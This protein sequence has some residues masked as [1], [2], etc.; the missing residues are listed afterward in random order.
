MTPSASEPNVTLE[1][2]RRL[3][4]ELCDVSYVE[5]E[6][7]LDGAAPELAA[8]VRELLLADAEPEQG[9]DAPIFERRSADVPSARYAGI[10]QEGRV[11]GY[12]YQLSSDLSAMLAPTRNAPDWQITVMCDATEDRCDQTRVGAVPDAA[13]P[14]VVAMPIRIVSGSVNALS[15]ASCHSEKSPSKPRATARATN[16]DAAPPTP[17][18]AATSS[19][20]EVI[21]TRVESW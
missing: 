7:R 14:V 18:N 11:A 5:Q 16:A 10:W 19:G 13:L 8:L 4:D 9:I 20:I 3:F 2:A 17:L 21:A 12:V 1:A 15:G 6:A